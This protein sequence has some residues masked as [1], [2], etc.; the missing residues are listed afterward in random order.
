M[1]FHSSQ[2]ETRWRY[3][4]FFTLFLFIT[5]IIITIINKRSSHGYCM[6]C[7]S[8]GH[9]SYRK[10]VL[11]SPVS[12]I[13][14]ITSFLRTEVPPNCGDSQLIYKT[15]QLCTFPVTPLFS[16]FTQSYLS[17]PRPLLCDGGTFQFGHESS[18]ESRTHP[19]ENRI[20][21]HNKLLT[22]KFVSVCDAFRCPCSNWPKWHNQ[23][24]AADVFLCKQPKGRL[25]SCRDLTCRCPWLKMTH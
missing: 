3:G 15:W 5:I 17:P 20:L 4:N 18:S 9:I 11:W 6:L 2:T 1:E 16:L 25:F 23:T 12:F 7:F 13:G 10:E 14:H 19:N 21:A 24:A 8:S 22:E